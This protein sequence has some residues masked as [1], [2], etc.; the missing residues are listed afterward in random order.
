M[1]TLIVHMYLHK[2]YFIAAIED[3]HCVVSCLVLE[4]SVFCCYCY[5]TAMHLMYLTEVAII[6]ILLII[7]AGKSV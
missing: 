1:L 3:V 5:Q 6:V 2:I 4:Y 7:F